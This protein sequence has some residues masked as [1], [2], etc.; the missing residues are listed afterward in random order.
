MVG[1]GKGK[2]QGKGLCLL[3]MTPSASLVIEGE[4]VTKVAAVV[5]ERTEETGLMDRR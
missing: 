5:G 4:V 2:E 1:K 3:G